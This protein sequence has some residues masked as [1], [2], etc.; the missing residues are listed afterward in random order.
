MD[1]RRREQRRRTYLGGEVDIHPL[2]ARLACLVRNLSPDGAR[3]VF[4]KPVT[5]PERF[6][7]VIAQTGDHRNVR[8]VWHSATEAGVAFE[9]AHT[10][11]DAV[12]SLAATR[13]I[14]HLEEERDL[15]A[16]QLADCADPTKP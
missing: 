7:L 10:E 14:R 6:A 5:I 8:I 11:D 9:E 12:I 1:E 15:L 2:C 16:R 4:A 3:L 13:R